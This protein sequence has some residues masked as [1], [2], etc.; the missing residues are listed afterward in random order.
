LSLPKILR[1]QW[2]MSFPQPDNEGQ[3][4]CGPA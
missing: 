4:V 1:S 2:R 3:E